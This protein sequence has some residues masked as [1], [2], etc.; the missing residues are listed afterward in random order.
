VN[1]VLTPAGTTTVDTSALTLSVPLAHFSSYVGALQVPLNLSCSN[2]YSD[3]FEQDSGWTSVHDVP[4]SFLGTAS[5]TA[6]R[7]TDVSAAGSYSL[8]DV[9]ANNAPGCGDRVLAQKQLYS[10]AQNGLW[11]YSV[12]AYLPPSNPSVGEAPEIRMRNTRLMSGG[13]LSATAGIQYSVQ[14]LSVYAQTAPGQGAWQS[15]SSPTS[16]RTS[17]SPSRFRAPPCSSRSTS[18]RFRFRSRQRG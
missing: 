6:V 11:Q 9:A 5:G 15:A 8:E 13:F 14:G 7:S 2:A 3:G 18:R 12:E 1:G 17:T 16:A 4:P 10:M